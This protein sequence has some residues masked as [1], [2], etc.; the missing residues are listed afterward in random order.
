MTRP[1]LLLI[2]FLA[3]FAGVSR[4][5]DARPDSTPRVNKVID[6]GVAYLKKWAGDSFETK[7]NYERGNT[8]VGAIALAGLTLLECGVPADDAA[9]KAVAQRVREADFGPLNTY[10]LATSVLFL[11]RLGDAGDRERIQSLC[12]QIMNGQ[13]AHGGWPYSCKPLSAA[14][15]DKVLT[16]LKNTPLGDVVKAP[17]GLDLPVFRYRRGAKATVTENVPWDDAS[18]TQFAVLALWAGKRHG[19][20][21]ER[22]LLMAEARFRAMQ[23]RDGSWSYR[24]AFKSNAGDIHRDSM[25][26]AGL[27]ALAVGRGVDGEKAK[28]DRGG[29]DAIRRGFNFLQESV[30]RVRQRRAASKG[31]RILF[32]SGWGDLYYLWSLERVAVVYEA[33]KIHGVDWYHWGSEILMNAQEEDGSWSDAFAGVPDTCFALLFLKRVNIVKDLTTELRSQGVILIPSVE[34]GK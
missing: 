26:C 1:L 30:G 11:D 24:Q 27:L 31:G 13:T 19:V 7:Y 4:A 17:A 8:Q 16:A 5:A 3:L 6:K 33:K 29:D 14:D 25:T 12:A 2:P 21:V 18:I 9:V 28:S 15:R 20:P 10:V 22:S 34:S 23:N 32:V